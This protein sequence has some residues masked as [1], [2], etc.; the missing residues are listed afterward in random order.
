MQ[1]L[2]TLNSRGIVHCD[3]KSEN[4]LLTQDCQLRM[5]DFGSAQPVAK[6]AQSLVVTTPEYLAP[7]ALYFLE[8][9]TDPAAMKTL[10]ASVNVLDVWSFGI[11]LLELVLGFPVYMGYRGRVVGQTAIGEAQTGLLAGQ[12]R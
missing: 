3:L 7:E 4:I 2:I 11:V 8:N 12:Q 9:S 6:I 10:C 5:I 1:A